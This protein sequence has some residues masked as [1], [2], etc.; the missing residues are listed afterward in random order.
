MRHI[1]NR[2]AYYR[3]QNSTALSHHEVEDLTHNYVVYALKAID[4]FDS[5]KGT[6]TSYINNWLRYAETS[7]RYDHISG[8]VFR[9]PQ[10]QKL[11]IVNNESDANNFPVYIE[12]DEYLSTSVEEDVENMEALKILAKIADP[13]GFARMALNIEEVID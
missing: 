5:S 3:K 13:K 11:K 6:L 10:D 12:D 9:L 7:P 8:Y 2:V 4:K 1:V